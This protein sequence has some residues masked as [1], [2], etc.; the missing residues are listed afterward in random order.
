[1]GPFNCLF[2][3]PQTF[4]QG[5]STYS[6]NSVP[7][8][9]PT[10]SPRF[11][12]FITFSPPHIKPPKA[13]SQYHGAWAL[14]QYLMS[15]CRVRPAIRRPCHW[16]IYSQSCRPSIVSPVS[17]QGF[18]LE[19]F[20]SSTR[21]LR[22]AYPPLYIYSRQPNLGLIRIQKTTQRMRLYSVTA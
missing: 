1:M 16:R 7:S 14:G 8:Q 17:L 13:T 15:P 21:V 5:A 4:P 3:L 18:R 22:L 12:L 19:S 2:F 9:H 10:G 11:T 6:V 20:G